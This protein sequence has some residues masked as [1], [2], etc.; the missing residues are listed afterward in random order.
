MSSSIFA[1]GAMGFASS[2]SGR[3]SSCM[4][5]LFIREIF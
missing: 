5:Y 1:S 2:V 4:L 3:K